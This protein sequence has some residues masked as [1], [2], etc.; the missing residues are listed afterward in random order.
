MVIRMKQ[1][2]LKTKDRNKLI[3]QVLDRL[4]DIPEEKQL[5]VVIRD[6]VRTNR[7]N[8]AMHLYLEQLATA[9]N[10]NNLHFT[11]ILNVELET[12]W[13]GGMIKEVI[14]RKV[15]EAMTGKPSSTKLTTKELSDIAEAIEIALAKKGIDIPFPSIDS[16][17]LTNNNEHYP[18]T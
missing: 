16:L 5:E 14:W 9:F 6:P 1:I 15:Q 13:T 12:H 4:A 11:D 8:A 18:R 2:I 7:Q 17:I 3:E 10:D